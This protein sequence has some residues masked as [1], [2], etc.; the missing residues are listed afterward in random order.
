MNAR[1]SVGIMQDLTQSLLSRGYA[2]ALAQTIRTLHKLH[3][4][5]TYNLISFGSFTF[6]SQVAGGGVCCLKV[7]VGAVDSLQQ[8]PAS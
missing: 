5:L 8:G 3:D 1:M 6:F 7:W 2:T 4:V